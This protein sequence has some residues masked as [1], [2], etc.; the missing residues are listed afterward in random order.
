MKTEYRTVAIDS[1]AG[2]TE[3]ETLLRNGWTIVRS[4]M[5]YI[6]FKRRVAR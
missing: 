3:A 6:W 5:F 1:L 4:G 2:I